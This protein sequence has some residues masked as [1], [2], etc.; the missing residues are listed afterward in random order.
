MNL[1]ASLLALVGTWIQMRQ[2][3]GMLS[4]SDPKGYAALTVVQGWRS[5]HRPVRHPV[6]WLRARS[7]VKSLLKGSPSEALDYRRAARGVFA[8]LCLV[9]AA[10][11]FVATSFC[12]LLRTSMH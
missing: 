9:V 8:W 2:Q 11:I 10:G 6:R 12:D 3:L 7:I 1:I 4:A 5:E